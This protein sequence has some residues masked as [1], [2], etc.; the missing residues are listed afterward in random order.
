MALETATYISDLVASN[1]PGG[2]GLKQADDH[3]RL[4]KATIQAS[5][6]NITG[7]MTVTHT[8]LNGLDARLSAVEGDYLPLAGGTLTGALIGTTGNFSGAFT[9]GGALSVGGAV[10]MNSHLIN[11]VTDPVSAQDAATKNY[12]DTNKTKV[13]VNGTTVTTQTV[14]VGTGTPS[15]GSHGDLYLKY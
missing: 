7:A 12:V 4:I 11:E 3:L 6:P 10:D 13:S 14:T 8:V 1:P 9:I 2:D 5:F 15:G